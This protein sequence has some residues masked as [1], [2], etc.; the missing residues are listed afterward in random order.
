MTLQQLF[1]RTETRNLSDLQYYLAEREDWYTEM[2]WDFPDDIRVI[3]KSRCLRHLMN[4]ISKLE[5]YLEWI[6]QLS[7]LYGSAIASSIRV[8]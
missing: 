5:S 2:S 3:K 1:D 8:L 4:R 6:E 7:P